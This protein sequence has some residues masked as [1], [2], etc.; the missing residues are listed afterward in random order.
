VAHVPDEGGDP[1]S[2][3]DTPADL[4]PRER[5]ALRSLAFWLGLGVSC[6]FAYLAVRDAQ[7]DEVADA[8]TDLQVAW[9]IPV[10]IVLALTFYLRA[11]R[12]RSLFVAERR[13]P[14]RDVARALFV[15]YLF[16]AILPVRAGE[17]ARIVALRRRG[18]VPIAEATGTA[19][20]E[21]VF[22]VLSLLC[23]LLV[24]LPW[25][26]S[27]A[28]R[29]AAF[30]VAIALG[31]S[32]VVAIVI[33]VRFGDRLAAFGAQK[34]ARL[35]PVSEE[36]LR[37]MAT[38]LLSGLAGLRRSTIGVVGFAWTT[39]SWLTLG[40]GC[41]LLMYAFAI[42]EPPLAGMLV[43]I[44]IGLAHI[45]PSSAAALGVFEGAT[46]IALAAYGVDASQALSYAIVLHAISVLPFLIGA[47]FVLASYRR[48]DSAGAR[49]SRSS[50]RFRRG[51]QGA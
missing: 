21:R 22:D 24:F 9:L 50:Q 6:L 30:A 19:V 8:L 14:L 49:V 18:R 20:V 47:P 32:L 41:W 45:V 16:N 7:F 44:A 4:V 35:L 23:L 28:W 39:A 5:R 36:R 42:R 38:H 33:L 2:S 1:G 51:R 43:V 13:P 26:P 48:V 27:L 3:A 17:P 37:P 10:L 34:L 25:F 29:T 31:A 12:W 46:V 15:G 40:V 11:L